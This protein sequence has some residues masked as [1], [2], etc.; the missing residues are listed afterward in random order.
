[1]KLV[2]NPL[3]GLIGF[4]EANF[5]LIN[6]VLATSLFISTPTYALDAEGWGTIIKGVTEVLQEN[7]QQEIKQREEQQRLEQQ[8]LQEQQAQQLRQQN[9]QLANNSDSSNQSCKHFINHKVNT[10]KKWS[11][12]CYK[13][14]LFGDGELLLYLSSLNGH[15]K[16]VGR[17]SEGYFAG[18]T[19]RHDLETN[20]QILANTTHLI[21]YYENNESL[22]IPV[23]VKINNNLKGYAYKDFDWYSIQAGSVR[24]DRKISFDEAMTI[25]KN[26]MATKVSDSMS[27]ERFRAYLE[28]KLVFDPSQAVAQQTSTLPST[29]SASEATD[30]APQKGTF[31]DRRKKTKLKTKK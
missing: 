20:G 16:Y 22:D 3:N 15:R 21:G 29:E 23:A 25:V 31:L 13:G 19:L 26:F 2:V 10:I 9:L 27:Y 8:R 30:E 14:Y 12:G 4:K 1:M 11:G 24:L 7:Q 18:V 6:C 5:K 28:G 17:F